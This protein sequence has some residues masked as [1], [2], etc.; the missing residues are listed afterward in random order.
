MW[1][2]TTYTTLTCSDNTWSSWN[3]SITGTCTA[4]NEIVWGEWVYAATAGTIVTSYV[5]VLDS[6]EFRAR[7]AERAAERLKAKERAERLL[8]EMLSEAQR[9]EMEAYRY[10]TVESRTSK[11]RYRVKTNMGRHGNIEELDA[12]GRVVA[13]LC[14]AP[15]GSIPDAD[16]LLGQKLA[17]EADEDEFRKAAN[18]TQRRA[19]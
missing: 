1:P 12:K 3:L 4:S 2:D 11:R 7:E 19:A 13:T 15:K 9:A 14:C 18:F 6:E 16:A 8:E 5:T 17:L 10:F